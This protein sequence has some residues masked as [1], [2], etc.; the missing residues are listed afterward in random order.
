MDHYAVG[1][2]TWFGAQAFAAWAGGTLPTEA[3]WE[4]ACRGDKGTLPFGI[5]DGT[6]LT[7]EMAMF[8]GSYP[9]ELPRGHYN[10]P[11]A[12]DK[13]PPYSGVGSYPYPNSYGLYDMHGNVLEWCSDQYQRVYQDGTEENPAVDPVGVGTN[14]MVA[15]GGGM[16]HQSYLC[17]S[18][19]RF[20]K[21][22]YN[23]ATN[24]GFRIIK[25]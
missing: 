11:T 5:G 4:F 20:F 22:Q 17:R 8:N 6:K 18:A 9:Y 7:C 24:L 23:Y 10:D 25:Y 13:V 2:V 19:A 12:D 1:N 21:G 14:G 3:Q 15:R 16:G